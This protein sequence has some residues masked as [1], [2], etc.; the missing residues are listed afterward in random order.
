[1]LKDRRI[2]TCS[3]AGQSY[4]ADNKKQ[5]AFSVQSNI[6]NSRDWLH[7]SSGDYNVI[8]AATTKA[9]ECFQNY[10]FLFF[11]F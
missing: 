3:H 1:V 11:L 9:K 2:Y 8:L 5:L 10:S 4:I 7:D 6:M